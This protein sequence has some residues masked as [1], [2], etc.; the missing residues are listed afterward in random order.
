MSPN[1]ASDPFSSLGT[2]SSSFIGDF[3][4][5]PMDN[6]EHPLLYLPV[7]GKVPQ[8]TVIS[9]SC[10]QALVSICHSVWFLWLFMG[11]V[12]KLGSLLIVIPS[13]SLLDFV[14]VTPS[15]GILFS[16]LRRI[17][18]FWANMHLSVS[19]YHVCSFVIG[20]PHCTG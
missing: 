20:L 8:E 2:F 14:S 5:H 10:Q 3:V 19:E 13:V 15:M 9:G 1:G 4:L 7:I 6:C 11:G 18:S 12:P 17:L 16:I